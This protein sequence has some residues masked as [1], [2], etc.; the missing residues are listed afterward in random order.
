[1]N[2]PLL[3]ANSWAYLHLLL[4]YSL[5]AGLAVWRQLWHHCNIVQVSVEWSSMLQEH[6]MEMPCSWWCQFITAFSHLFHLLFAH[7]ATGGPC[8]LSLAIPLWI[9]T[10]DVASIACHCN[11]FATV[12]LVR[13][14]WCCYCYYCC[15]PNGRQTFYVVVN[16][17][18]CYKGN[19]V[20]EVNIL[21]PFLSTTGCCI[22]WLSCLKQVLCGCRP[23]TVEQPSSFSE[24]NRHWLWTV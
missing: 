15:W 11:D 5:C 14:C 19:S 24:T 18:I 16:A 13:N 2:I 10:P 7:V 21:M 3:V 9:D 6:Q 20:L 8:Q 23:K 22:D 1:M 17:Y 4:F 12:Q